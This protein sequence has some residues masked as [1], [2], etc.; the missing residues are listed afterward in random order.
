MNRT[1]ASLAGVAFFVVLAAAILTQN[2]PGTNSSAA[3]VLAYY[4]DH[5]TSTMV[6]ALLTVIAVVVGILFYGLLRDYLRQDG[7]VRGLSATGFGGALFFGASGL[8]GA[9]ALGALTDSPSHLSAAAAQSLYLVDEDASFAFASGG[10]ALMLFAF[11][12]AIL[13]SR[14]LPTWLGWVAFPLALCALAPPA[15]F[16]ALVGTGLWTLISSIAMYRRQRATDAT[17]AA[18]APA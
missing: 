3:K 2:P 5:R 6:S 13:K 18:P 9:G 11:G 10:I 4:N 17:A 14:L 8:I 1:R 7:A 16:V 12:L 15:G